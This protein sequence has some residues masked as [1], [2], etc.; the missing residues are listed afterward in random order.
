MSDGASRSLA[1]SANGASACLITG[2]DGVVVWADGPSAAFVRSPEALVGTP[3]R[4]LLDVD[5]AVCHGSSLQWCRRGDGTSVLVEVS[6]EECELRGESAWRVRLTPARLRGAGDRHRSEWHGLAA[7]ALEAQLAAVGLLDPQGAVLDCNA[8]FALRLGCSRDSL[9]GQPLWP[10]IPDPVRSTARS[11]FDEVAQ[12]G[13]SVRHAA[14]ADNVW[15]DFVLHPVLAHDGEL[16]AVAVFGE[17]VTEQ[18]RI[19]SAATDRYQT[20]IEHSPNPIM[21]VRAGRY[22]FVNP[23]GARMLGF[24]HPREVEGLPVEALLSAES[25]KRARERMARTERSEA[26]PPMELEIVRPDGSMMTSISTFVPI[27]L[28][29]G[30]AILVI[31]QDITRRKAAEAALERSEARLRMALEITQARVFELDAGASLLSYLR[32]ALQR[33]LGT[34]VME[35]S[36]EVLLRPWLEARVHDEERSIAVEKVAELLR[37]E[38]ETT[39][40]ECRLRSDEG[41]WVHVVVTAAWIDGRLVGALRDVTAERRL[42]ARV[43]RAEKF[44]ALGQLAAGLAHD[45]NNQLAG[46]MGCAEV[47]SEQVPTATVQQSVTRIFECS[48]RSAQLVRQLLQFA[49]KGQYVASTVDLHDVVQ[50][51]VSEAI[52]NVSAPVEVSWR[53]Q[54]EPSTTWGDRAQ[55]GDLLDNLVCNALEAMP[56]GGELTVTSELVELDTSECE[57][58][59]DPVRPGSYVRLSVR[60]T[61]VGMSAGD[62]SRVFDPFFTTKK[63]LGG[64]G[65][66]LAAA[67]GTAN[68]HGGTVQCDSEIGAGST[69]TVLLPV[70]RNEPREDG[71]DTPPAATRPWRIL[72]VDDEQ[73]VREVAVTLLQRMGYEVEAYSGGAEAVA[74][75]R[76]DGP[77]PDL[78]VLDV[79]MPGMNGPETLNA[80]REIDPEVP[81]LVLSGAEPSAGADS[82]LADGCVGLV[83]KPFRKAELRAAVQRVFEHGSS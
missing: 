68:Q 56:G 47:L 66:G 46:I 7:V 53:L 67:Y 55:L 58:C 10:L 23:A 24:S 29:D 59:G 16:T 61:G 51:V 38:C 21:L 63:E 78:V 83:S 49:G 3:L 17:D 33:T 42:E 8:V 13:C 40:F 5:F 77:R 20:I 50:K 26:N 19:S 64:S 45:L 36:D 62:Q 25:A 14:C 60:D 82:M 31:G 6:T 48:E 34:A 76:E 81:V 72:V 57:A 79:I 70:H 43:Q 39:R 65:M 54:A 80:V 2:R 35:V 30:P 69:F 27:E 15:M 18:Y 4:A 44:E 41:E 12:T 1:H 28:E 37:H 32:Q 71:V 74:R 11:L 22:L 52:G 73:V 75:L 9:V